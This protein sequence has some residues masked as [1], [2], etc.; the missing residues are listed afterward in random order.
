MTTPIDKP[1]LRALWLEHRDASEVGRR[2]GLAPQRVGQIIAEMRKDD[3]SIP[4][5]HAQVAE[6]ARREREAAR[7][8]R[9]FPVGEL[10]AALGQGPAESPAP[11]PA[12]KFAIEGHK[13]CDLLCRLINQC[14]SLPDDGL[15]P[16]TAAIKALAEAIACIVPA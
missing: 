14:R 5:S 4:L 15:T 8:A 12:M 13:A 3:D 11:P 10:K 16:Q 7:L 6:K 1:L 2:C 9:R